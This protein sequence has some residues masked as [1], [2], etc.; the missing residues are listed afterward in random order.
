MTVFDLQHCS[1]I[2]SYRLPYALVSGAKNIIRTNQHIS[3]YTLSLILC[4]TPWVAE[5]SVTTAEGF[6]HH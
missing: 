6:V 1:N 5:D 3:G 4:N 2:I